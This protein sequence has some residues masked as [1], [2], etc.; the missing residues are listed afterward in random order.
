MAV[1]PISDEMRKLLCEL[2]TTADTVIPAYDPAKHGP[3][4]AVGDAI[5][6]TVTTEEFRGAIVHVDGK[7]KAMQI[8]ED[9]VYII[10]GGA[11]VRLSSGD[12]VPIPEGNF[13]IDKVDEKL[14]LVREFAESNPM[15]SLLGNRWCKHCDR[16]DGGPH[17][18]TCLWLRA[19]KMAGLS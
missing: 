2:R 3:M 6:T 14:A 19:G 13:S 1:K 18:D 7:P 10:N 8:Y 11:P 5:T 15:L 16:R 12:S 17:A 4:I 9:G